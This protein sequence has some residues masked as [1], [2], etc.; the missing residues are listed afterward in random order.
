LTIGTL[1]ASGRRSVAIAIERA[2]FLADR[3][4]AELARQRRTSQRHCWRRSATIC[5]R[6]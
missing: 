2:Q 3:D 1:D 4:A 6:R 5:A